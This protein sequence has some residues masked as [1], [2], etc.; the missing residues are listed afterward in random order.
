M[1]QQPRPTG[2]APLFATCACA[3]LLAAGCARTAA[4]NPGGSPARTGGSTTLT[5]TD[6]NDGQTV[7]V[8]PG[9]VL[10][11]VL[12]STYWRFEPNADASV[13]RPVASPTVSPSPGCVP[14][15]GCGTAAESFTAV[16][17]GHATVIA[18]RLSCGEAMLCTGSAGHYQINVAVTP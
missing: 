7:T 18:T 6:P 2:P 5:A 1:R 17:P 12:H 14:G 10:R 9:D 13:L 15:Q 4:V 8:H 3:L 16:A 11:V